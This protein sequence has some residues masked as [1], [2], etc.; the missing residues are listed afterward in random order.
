M[1]DSIPCWSGARGFVVFWFEGLGVAIG[2]G[3]VGPFC[4]GLEEKLVGF[5]LLALEK[6]SVIKSVELR[7]LGSIFWLFW[8]FKGKKEFKR[9]KKPN[10]SILKLLKKK[11]IQKNNCKSFIYN[12]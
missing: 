2:V 8:E 1:I 3:V 6:S 10:L 4:V 7:L 11:K 9:L 5:C 12:V